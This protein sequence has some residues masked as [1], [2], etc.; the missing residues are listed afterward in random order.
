VGQPIIF[1]DITSLIFLATKEGGVMRAK[2]LS[3]RIHLATEAVEEDGIHNFG[4][5]TSKMIADGLARLWRERIKLP[6]I[7]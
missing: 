7:S 2:N 4:L 1:Q 3:T 5:H 6:S